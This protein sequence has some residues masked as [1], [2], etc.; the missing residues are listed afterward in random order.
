MRI[1]LLHHLRGGPI[2]VVDADNEVVLGNGLR[3]GYPL[4]HSL[5]P[6]D[7]L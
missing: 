7:A 3:I 4:M 5:H 6:C 1:P 2:S